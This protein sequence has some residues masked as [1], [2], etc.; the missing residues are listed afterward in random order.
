MRRRVL[1]TSLLVAALGLSAWA[2]ISAGANRGPGPYLPSRCDNEKIQ[3]R[4]V[5]IGCAD[6][7]FALR[8]LDWGRSWA[9]NESVAHLFATR[10]PATLTVMLPILILD[11][12]VA[13][14]IAMWVAYRRGSL[15][16]RAIM[17][18]STLAYSMSASATSSS[19]RISPL[20]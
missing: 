7:S 3:P 15:G 8:G 13:L 2:A 20:A 14:P 11:T 1:I 5:V 4:T 16:D 10:L 19:V 6:F 17:I 9:T 12:L 18:A